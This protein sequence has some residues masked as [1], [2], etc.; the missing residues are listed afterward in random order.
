MK[1]N[2]WWNDEVI[3]WMNVHRM[4]LKPEVQIA[5]R[6]I[7]GLI[8]L[9]LDQEQP[10]PMESEHEDIDSTPWKE[11]VEEVAGKGSK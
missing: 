9:H 11:K 6:Q 10:S 3:R 1:T 4:K 5:Q 8:D 2:N 7:P